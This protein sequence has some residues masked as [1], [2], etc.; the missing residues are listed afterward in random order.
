MIQFAW[1]Y[2]NLYKQINM[3]VKTEVLSTT[4]EYGVIPCNSCSVATNST[5]KKGITNL[6]DELKNKILERRKKEGKSEIVVEEK[7]A[8]TKHQV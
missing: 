5:E 4:D 3:E 6:K 8:P 7:P 1:K 2:E